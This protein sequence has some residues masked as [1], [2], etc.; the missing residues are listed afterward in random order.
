M[1]S[2]KRNKTTGELVPATGITSQKWRIYTPNQNKDF[3]ISRS[4]FNEF[5]TCPRC[6]YLKT[7]RGFISPSIP[8]F[9]L[10]AL[11]DTLLKKEFDICRNKQVPHHI[12]IKNNLSHIVPYKTKKIKDN[13]GN[14]KSLID[15]WRD[16]LHG[17]IKHRFKDT[18]I[19]LQGGIDD[20]WFN[21]KTEELIVV[22]YKSQQDNNEVS[23]D[24]YFKKP[25]KEGYKIQ[26]DFYA[27]L[28]KGL[29]YKVSSDSY[30]YI[31]NAKEIGEFSGKMLFD[32]ILIHY[33]VNTDYHEDKI[34]KMID[35]MNSEKV[36]DSNGSCENCAYA[37]QRSEIDKLQN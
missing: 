26:M 15:V 29:G 22:D 14:E 32:E 16:S 23:Q 24:T 5:L 31:C 17:G 21:T 18:N 36:P 28:L 1:I 25:Y 34:Q 12:L 27:Y 8:G 30:L 19:M 37:R 20:V 10:N 6:F 11:T 13:N 33:K 2:L 7:N 4:R 9:T 3:P 35:I